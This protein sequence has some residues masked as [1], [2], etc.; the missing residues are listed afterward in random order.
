MR[1]AGDEQAFGALHAWYNRHVHLWTWQANLRDQLIRRRRELYRCFAA[2][3]AERFDCVF[4]KDIALRRISAK[5]PSGQN[6]ASPPGTRFHSK[7][8]IRGCGAGEPKC[9]SH[10]HQD[11]QQSD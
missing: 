5:S 3:L 6:G 10:P 7:R 4:L 8:R 2:D 1:F 9:R 11:H